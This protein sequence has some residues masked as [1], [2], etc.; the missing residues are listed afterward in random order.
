MTITQRF[1]PHDSKGRPTLTPSRLF[2]CLLLSLMIAGAQAAPVTYTLSG[3]TFSDTATA[4]GSFQYDAATKTYSN[5]NVTTTG[6]TRAGETY[7]SVSSGF[8]GDSG[9]VLLVTAPEGSQAGLPGLSL[10]FSPVL[11]GTAGT[12]T[13]T[14]QEAGCSDSGC[15]VP[16]GTIR[17]IAAG[18]VTATLGVSAPVRWF[19]AGVTFADGATATGSFTFNAGTGTFSNVNITTHSGSR[20]GATHSSVSGGITADTAGVLFV[21]STAPNQT[22]LPGF[23]MFFSPALAATGGS[24]GLTGQEANCADPSCSTPNGTTRLVTAGF[25]TSTPLLAISKNHTGNFIQGD[26]GDVYTVVVTNVSGAPTT[27][28]LVTVTENPPSGLSV[29]SIS[30]SGW[31]CSFPTCTRSDA[32]LTGQSY[33]AISITVNVAVNA[34]ASVTNQVTVIGGGSGPA[35]ASDPT[36]IVAPPPMLTMSKSHVGS[37][38]QGQVGAQYTISVRNAGLGAAAGLV[39]MTET[40]PSGLTVTAMSGTGWTCNTPTCI[41]ADALPAGA[42][43][44]AVTVTASVSRSATS[45]LVNTASVSGGGSASAAVADSTVVTSTQSLLVVNRKVLNFGIS[46]S[47]ITSPQTVLV[48]IP[49]VPSAA[50]TATSDHTNITVSPGSGVGT[51]TFQVSTISGASG[52]V[53]VTVPG[54]SNTTQ[55]IQVN[56][57]NVVP[58]LPSGN[59]DTP[60][61]GV[62]GVIGAIPVTGWVLDN[63]EVAHVDIFRE[64]VTGEIPGDLIFIGTATFSAD[65]RP[66]VESLFPAFPL[67]YR[68][69]WGYQLLTNVLSNSSGSGAPGN[70]TYKL[71]AV[72]FDTAGLQLDLGTKTITVDNAHAT[73]PFGAIDTPTQ[74][75]TISGTNSVN[76]G[77]ALTPQTGMIPMDGSTITV[78]IDGVLSGSPTYNQFRSDIATFFPGYKNSNGAVGFFYINTTALANGVHTISW[79][80]FDDLGRGEGLGSRY[81]TVQ[82]TSGGVAAPEDLIEELA[83]RKAVQVR[84][85]LNGNRRPETISEDSDGTYSVTMEEVGLIELHL[86][87]ASGNSLVQGEARALPTGS[88]LKGGVFYWQPGPGFLGEYTMRFARPDGTAIPVRVKI[89]PKRYPIQ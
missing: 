30:G 74:G 31:T 41:R 64:P 53:T 55:T 20:N 6:A 22:G 77:W 58:T 42:S 48:T 16:S 73:K 61:S 26:I 80:V 84:H 85:G 8:A 17:S 11:P 18:S 37:F 49:T 19:L 9:G 24:S 87:A 32:L 10:L 57:K 44:P 62:T 1:A 40:P 38:A 28:G 27:T 51:G 65:A 2:L 88:T 14:G 71:H 69:G 43:F 75:G 46:G 33:P 7:N 47:L 12:A 15:T 56:V 4:S 70:G 39:T 86:G 79:N 36:T 35:T 89:V 52:A 21:T 72:A 78:V 29:T 83:T 81:F 59:F 68:A 5:V 23:S 82:N 45:P 3:V 25:V 67:Q 63:I 60:A 66:D 54:V 50:W 13:L 76:F 34:P